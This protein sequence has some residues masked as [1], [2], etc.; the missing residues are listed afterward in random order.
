M[1]RRCLLFEGYRE[2]DDLAIAYKSAFYE[3][4]PAPVDAEIVVEKKNACGGSCRH[5]YLFEG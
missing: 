3:K 4:C 1:R 5:W 2:I